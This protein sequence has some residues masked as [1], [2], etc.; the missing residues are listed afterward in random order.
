MQDKGE[1]KMQDKYDSVASKVAR[2]AFT[3]KRRLFLKR[4]KTGATSMQD[5]KGWCW[6]LYK[7]KDKHARHRCETCEPT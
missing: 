4:F 7:V 5:K 1:P 6:V 2:P 3:T